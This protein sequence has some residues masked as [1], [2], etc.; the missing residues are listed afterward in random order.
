MSVQCTGDMG[1]VALSARVELTP[2]ALRAA[3]GVGP[4]GV[5]NVTPEGRSG[6]RQGGRS[7]KP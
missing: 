4:P 1:L 3:Q 7:K 2:Y 5:L 6:E